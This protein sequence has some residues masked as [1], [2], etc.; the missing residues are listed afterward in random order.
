MV[1]QRWI[2]TVATC[3]PV[4]MIFLDA[5]VVNVAFPDIRSSFPGASLADLSWVLSAYSIC[6]AAMLVPFGRLAD[7]RSAR[8]VFLAG[9]VV[10]VLASMLCAGAS[11]VPL[12]IAA[13]ALQGIGAAA[14]APTAQALLMASVSSERRA[15]ALSLLAAVG[16]VAAALGPPI[17]ALLV[18]SGDWRIVFLINLP[19]GAVAF[20]LGWGLPGARPERRPHRPDIAGAAL[21]AAVVAAVA[22]GLVQGPWWGWTDARTA[23]AFGFAAVGL[24]VFL[25]RCARHR[26]PV[27][28]L[29]LFAIRSFSA[30][31]A[32]TLLIGIAFYGLLLGNSLFL[33][34]AWGWS[35]LEAGLALATTPLVTALVALPAT[36]LAERRGP[37]AVLTV[38]SL[39]VAAG[40]TWLATRMTGE[41][42]FAGAWL[43]GAVL[44]GVG[45]GLA[46]PLFSAITVR[47]LNS[48]EFGLGSGTSAMTRQM[49][50]VLGV[51]I[52]VAVV[53][54]PGPATTLSAFRNGW[55]V[56]VVVSL[57]AVAP[58]LLLR[59]GAPSRTGRP[60]SPMVAR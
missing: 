44:A 46:Y 5:T 29:P 24:P 32:G 30:G 21:I 52:L 16:G 8:H 38:G 58:A 35:I 3:I 39:V 12:L 4:F 18:E 11:T 7:I 47:D 28:P 22:L 33:T 2:H 36:K 56:A 54:E 1:R 49:G 19:V 23:G 40:A 17:G 48:D 45:L 10:F 55:L 14:I 42:D 60:R 57:L 13:R 20:L 50:A 26:E 6:F 51:T 9:M 34:T 31:N 25:A 27:L 59:A 53:G 15:S 43:P 41:A 37:A